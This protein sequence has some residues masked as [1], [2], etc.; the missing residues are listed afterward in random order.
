MGSTC[1]DADGVACLAL[2]LQLVARPVEFVLSG[3]QV[4]LSVID[5]VVENVDPFLG[6]LGVRIRLLDLGG[7]VPDRSFDAPCVD[8]ILGEL[9]SCLLE[10][11]GRGLRC[12][13]KGLNMTGLGCD[14]DSSRCTY[15]DDGPA[16]M[17]EFVNACLGVVHVEDVG[18]ERPVLLQSD[19]DVVHLPDG[20]LNMIDDDWLVVHD[21]LVDGGL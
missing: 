6:R 18:G 20:A 14:V 1:P 19:D 7:C 9:V 10:P 3:A 17:M 15:V 4:G 21:S 13:T 8:Q 11:G 16:R 2:S 12:R 5:V